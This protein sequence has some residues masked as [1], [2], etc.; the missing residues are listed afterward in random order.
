MATLRC[1]CGELLNNHSC[2]N[3]TEGWLLADQDVDNFDP[4]ID[5]SDPA[6]WAIEVSRG[7]WE[8]SNCGRLA[9]NWPRRNGCDVKWYKP[10]DGEPGRLMEFQD[11]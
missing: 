1:P 8:C 2:P 10:E 11:A 6:L 7:A 3:E 5:E 4:S 9:F